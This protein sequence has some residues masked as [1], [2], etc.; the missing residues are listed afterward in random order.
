[1]PKVISKF[2]ASKGPWQGKVPNQLLEPRKVWASAFAQT[3]L[4]LENTCSM[5]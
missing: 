4:S 5:G 2:F 1:M 3:A